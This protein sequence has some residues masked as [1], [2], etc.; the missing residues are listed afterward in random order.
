MVRDTSRLAK[1][2]KSNSSLAS[3]KALTKSDKLHQTH[4]YYDKF[5]RSKHQG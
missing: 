2:P 3:S 5:T 4:T 1:P